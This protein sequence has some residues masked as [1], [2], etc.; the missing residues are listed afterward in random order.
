MKI[1]GYVDVVHAELGLPINELAK[2]KAGMLLE[3]CQTYSQC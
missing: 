2:L 1:F 3:L